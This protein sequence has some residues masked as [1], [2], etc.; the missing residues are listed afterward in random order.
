M[1]RPPG[2]RPIARKKVNG[3]SFCRSLVLRNCSILLCRRPLRSL[4]VTVHT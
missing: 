4:L 2:V 1:E 3:E